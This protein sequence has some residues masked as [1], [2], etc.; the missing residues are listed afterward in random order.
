LTFTAIEGAQVPPAPNEN[1]PELV[2]I[3]NVKKLILARIAK[4]GNVKDLL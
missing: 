2:D 4:T 1:Q 3:T